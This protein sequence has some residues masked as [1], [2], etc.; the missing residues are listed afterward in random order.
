M[1]KKREK[2]ITSREEYEKRLRMVRVKTILIIT[3]PSLIVLS[4]LAILFSGGK[5]LTIFGVKNYQ[6]VINIF[7][8]SFY[9]ITAIV[10]V[11]VLAFATVAFIKS[12]IAFIKDLKNRDGR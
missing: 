10:I 3:I 1:V 7:Y 8:G 4:L 6:G 12:I 5:V 2:P 11:V 9:A